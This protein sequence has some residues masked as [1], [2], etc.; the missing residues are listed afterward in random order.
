MTKTTTVR[1]ALA[2][3][4]LRTIALL[5]Q[6]TAVLTAWDPSDSADAQAAILPD[7]QA[8]IEAVR[9]ADA[10]DDAVEI[11]RMAVLRELHMAERRAVKALSH[12]FAAPFACF[13]A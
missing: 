13:A 3:A 10:H 1:I 12:P 6:A 7:L 11:R 2:F 5:S 8:A 4:D 9:G